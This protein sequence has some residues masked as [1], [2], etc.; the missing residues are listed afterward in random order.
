MRKSTLLA[1]IIAAST[2]TVI[3][4]NSGGDWPQWRGPNRD[5]SLPTYAEPK[6]LPDKLTQHW[7]VE[8]GTGYATPIVIG[9]RVFIF[10]RQEEKEVMRAL[11]A[12]SGKI[13]WET[14]YPASFNMNPATARHGP[15]PKATPT[16]AD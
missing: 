15:G 12:A 11:D 2:A 3:G 5:G 6:A 4:Q 9:N 16:Y 1:F 10:S 14:S 7:K 8:V 13:V